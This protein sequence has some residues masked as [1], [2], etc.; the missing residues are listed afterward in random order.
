MRKKAGKIEKFKNTTAIIFGIC[1]YAV[2]LS[3]VIMFLNFND[4]IIFN[5]AVMSI[6][7]FCC[8][9][10]IPAIFILITFA[11][12]SRRNR[13]EYC[14]V[15]LKTSSDGTSLDKSVFKYKQNKTKQT[16]M[17]GLC[18]LMILLSAA[19]LLSLILNGL[20][21]D[22]FQ[23]I[24]LSTATAVMLIAGTVFM[25]VGSLFYLLSGKT[26]LSAVTAVVIVTS[27]LSGIIW[28]HAQ[29]Y[30]KFTD[31]AQVTFLFSEK[32][33][34]YS[35]Y[36]IPSLTV[37]DKEVLNDKFGYALSDD[38][39]LALAEGRRDSAHDTGRIDI[40]G[41]I[42]FDGGETFG[43]TI[44]FFSFKNEV[45]KFGNPTAVFDTDTGLIVLAFMT[46][47]EKEDYY[48]RTAVTR[49]KLCED[50]NIVW[51]EPK[52][53]SLPKDES[54]V[55]SSSDGVRSDTLMVGPGKGLKLTAG[56]HIGRIIIPASNDGYSFVIYSDDNGITWHR[57]AS[58]GEG[59]ECEAALLADGTVVM[60]IRDNTN[61]SAYHPEQYQRL[62]YSY[63][64]GE[65]WTIKTA[66]T[67]LKSPICMSSVCTDNGGRLYLT[68][69]DSFKNRANLTLAESSDGGKTW[70]IKRLY[71]GASGYSS[72]TV[73]D[74]KILILA[75][76]G[77]VNYSESIVLISI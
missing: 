24:M 56:E 76:I 59:N 43:N 70:K 35:Y 36:R 46:A 69:P 23:P 34:G 57:G 26:I 77:K 31:D 7:A 45:G 41:K 75:E 21:L 10:V 65:T 15:F 38:V 68:Y 47:T 16:A 28:A 1:G 40:V 63:D 25:L 66:D 33:G 13:K 58:A 18:L 60:V 14:C 19:L 12:K 2:F 49:G 52:D 42:S 48:Y 51:E 27:Y 67:S 22:Y 29:G 39:V 3:A 32:E 53:I 20:L 54:A 37:L 64:G 6:I 55:G 11:T 71:S 74:A 50:G 62:S 17:K 8:L 73:T 44:T 72:V 30:Q 61:C 9:A 4:Q 5:T